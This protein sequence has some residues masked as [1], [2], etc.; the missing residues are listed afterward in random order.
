MFCTKKHRKWQLNNPF[1]SRQQ[2]ILS[3]C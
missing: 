3:N 1:S 2:A